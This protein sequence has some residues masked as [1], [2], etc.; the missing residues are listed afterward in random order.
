MTIHHLSSKIDSLITSQRWDGADLAINEAEGIVGQSNAHVV[1]AWRA[2]L[3]AAKG[4]KHASLQLRRAAKKIAPDCLSHAYLECLLLTELG[5]SDLEPTLT[6][7]INNS[8]KLSDLFFL[9][10]ARLRLAM[11]LRRRGAHGEVDRLKEQIATDFS[12]FI[13]AEVVHIKDV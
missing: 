11:C 10:E 5:S 13:G 4:D 6:E 12:A 8:L 7:L 3:A 2:D 1:L 9:D